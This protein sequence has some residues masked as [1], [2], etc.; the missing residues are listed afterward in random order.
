MKDIDQLVDTCRLPH[1]QRS[2]PQSAVSPLTVQDQAGQVPLEQQGRS[3]HEE[4]QEHEPTRNLHVAEI[5]SHPHRSG[6][7]DRGT[8][9]QSELLGAISKE[10][11]RIGAGEDQRGKPE[12]EE[13]RPT[14]VR[15]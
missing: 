11:S 2:A 1:D 6:G 10:P 7:E 8:C 13:H 5:G 14:E 9:H 4:G 12:G 3:T 15:W